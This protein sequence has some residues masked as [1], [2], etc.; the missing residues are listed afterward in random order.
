MPSIRQAFHDCIA[1]DYDIDLF[2][3]EEEKRF[4]MDK[5][6]KSGGQATTGMFLT[7]V[8]VDIN[9]AWTVVIFSI[10]SIFKN[11]TS[12]TCQSADGEEVLLVFLLLNLA[13][14]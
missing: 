2:V 12:S 14:S 6:I 9:N 10:I 1:D 5:K 13:D 11:R 7:L 4:L 8:T 3:L